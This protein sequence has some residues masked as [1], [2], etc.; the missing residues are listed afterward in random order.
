MSTR[1][2]IILNPYEQIADYKGGV[3]NFSFPTSLQW[4]EERGKILFG[5]H[6]AI[7]EHDYDLIY[8]L[9]VYAIGDHKNATRHGINLKKGILLT[10]PIGCG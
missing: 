2:K 6:F 1:T 9:L 4:M 5:K 10:G 7:S 3:F 8:K